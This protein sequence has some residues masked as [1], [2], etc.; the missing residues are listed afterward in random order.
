MALMHTQ[1]SLRGLPGAW[2]WH[3]STIWTAML[4]LMLTCRG[5]AMH[6]HD[7]TDIHEQLCCCGAGWC[8]QLHAMHDLTQTSQCFAVDQ[9]VP[10]RRQNTTTLRRSPGSAYGQQRGHARNAAH[11]MAL[12]RC[13]SAYQAPPLDFFWQAVGLVSCESGVPLSQSTTMSRLAGASPPAAS[14]RGLDADKWQR[15]HV[16]QP[17]AVAW[18]PPD[19]TALPCAMLCRLDQWAQRSTTMP[20]HHEAV[21]WCAWQLWCEPA[22]G[23]TAWP[24]GF[25]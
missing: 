17:V 7:D 20:K 3:D 21:A 11:G 10:H 5:D 8:C 2:R 25:T 22:G 24:F 18:W 6:A 15:G 13:G 4:T 23:P 16:G 1:H 12:S 19:I 9:S 14:W